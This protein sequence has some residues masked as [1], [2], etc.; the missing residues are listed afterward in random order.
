MGVRQHVSKEHGEIQ[1]DDD[2]LSELERLTTSF[3]IGII[4]MD[5]DDF[6]SSKVLF[7]ARTRESLDWETMNKLCEHNSD[8]NK[9]IEDIKIDFES[10]RIHKTEY[11]AIVESPED[12]I[13]K[14]RQR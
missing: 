12:H 1:D 7:A 14:M 9:F 5:L 2:L 13:K 11:D 6:D 4:E 3:G 8:F 10:K